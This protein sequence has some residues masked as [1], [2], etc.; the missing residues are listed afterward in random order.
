MSKDFESSVSTLMASQVKGDAQACIE[1]GKGLAR[2]I[3]AKGCDPCVIVT[4]PDG[5]DIV[6]PL[7]AKPAPDWIAAI[8]EMHDPDSFAKYFRHFQTSASTIFVDREA[9]K[10]V[11]ILNYHHPESPSWCSHRVT[12]TA[13]RS[14]EL[15]TWMQACKT[16]MTQ[17][18]FATLIEDQ[19]LTITKP[20]AATMMEIAQS[21]E[22]CKSGTF[23][24]VRRLDN[25]SFAFGWSETVEARAG[26]RGD[27]E[28]PREIR[29]TLRAFDGCAAEEFI[30][31]LRYKIDD[32]RLSLWIDL[33]NLDQLLADAFA[34][35]VEDIETDTDFGALWGKP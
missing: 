20:C 18:A 21:I 14:K 7:R 4:G 22:A 32:G 34:D 8:P 28:I 25:G 11:G 29:L 31:R 16:P 24:S 6:Y 1:A 27:L 26:S 5:G 3:E 33:L 9:F 13:R 12:W 19:A 23:K 30:A 15:Q 17:V 2:L 10:V 35:L